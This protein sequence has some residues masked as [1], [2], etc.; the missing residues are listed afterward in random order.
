MVDDAKFHLTGCGDD[1]SSANRVMQVA[2]S[3]HTALNEVD[4]NWVSLPAL[5]QC[6]PSG[7]I[8]TV[9]SVAGPASAP[10][11]PFGGWTAG[12]S[13]VIRTPDIIVPSGT[14]TCASG[15]FS[16]VS[17]GFFILSWKAGDTITIAGSS[18]TCTSNICTIQSVQSAVQVTLSQSL[19]ISGAAWKS[20]TQYGYL[21]RKATTTGAV[22]LSGVTHD[23]F[24]GNQYGENSNGAFR[25]FSSVSTTTTYSRA[26]VNDGLVRT[27]FCFYTI[28]FGAGLQ[29]Y[30]F[31]PA[32]GE[33]RYLQALNIS[34]S[35]API[36]D[37]VNPCAFFSSD[38]S[39]NIFSNQY[40]DTTYKETGWN[41]TK[42]TTADYCQQDGGGCV[43]NIAP[44]MLS[45]GTSLISKITTAYAA[46][47]V[48]STS[49]GCSYDAT[50]FPTFGISGA[51]GNVLVLGS[52]FA[53]VP[54]DA[55][56][57]RCYMDLNTTNV[58][59]C[60]DSFSKAPMGW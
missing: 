15:V 26:G 48:G 7:T 22:H 39:N 49:P 60:N 45:S 33:S 8:T 27:G 6:S 13:Q 30:F 47:C 59:S 37:T 2:L 4:S 52:T 19:T 44:V 53:G 29:L 18:P 56:A 28:T 51:I 46:Y 32:T 10:E 23:I 24:V 14:T 55:F 11:A 12:T 5:V 42:G 54:D 21:I 25:H 40:S 38:G 43:N 35:Y 31:I 20:T 57:M 36:W 1:A 3:E 16:F 34:G 50:H 41:A 9:S 58:L 17:G